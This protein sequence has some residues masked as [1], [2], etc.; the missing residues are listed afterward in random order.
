MPFTL[1]LTTTM[2][3]INRVHCNPTNN[4]SSPQPPTI[5][6]FLQLLRPVRRVRYRA[7]CRTAPSVDQLAHAGREPDQDAPC[8]GGLFQDFG[9]GAGGA[10]ELAAFVGAELD[11]VD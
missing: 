6:S 4:G 5:P 2:R 7:D 9:D 10:D 11:V 1:T 3:M 8:G